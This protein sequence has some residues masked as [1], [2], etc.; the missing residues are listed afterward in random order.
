LN[1]ILAFKIKGCSDIFIPLLTYIFNLSVTNGTFLSLW[2]QTD[3]VP[4]FKKGDSTI[5]SNYR[6]ISILNKF[7]DMFEFTIYDNLFNF[8]K[9]RLNPAQHG[10]RKSNSTTINLITFLNSIMPSVS[11][12]GQTDLVYFDLSNAFDISPHNILLLKLSIFF[13]FILVTLIGSIAM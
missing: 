9:N 3:V 6:P 13:Y 12:Q 11:T 4:V 5:V 2:K 10:F 8:C 7:S 1:G